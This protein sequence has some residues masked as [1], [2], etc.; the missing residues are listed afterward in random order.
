MMPLTQKEAIPSQ[1]LPRDPCSLVEAQGVPQPLEG[2]AWKMTKTPS[3]RAI[4]GRATFR[5]P[6]RPV[7]S[8]SMRGF[9]PM[10]FAD[11]IIHGGVKQ[12]SENNYFIHIIE[13]DLIVR[14]RNFAGLASLSF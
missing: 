5:G 10:N 2:T 1:D 9:Y 8:S 7:Y 4:A 13:E 11:K 3:L 12:L 14:L 6:G